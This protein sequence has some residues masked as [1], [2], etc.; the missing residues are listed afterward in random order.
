MLIGL[1]LLLLEFIIKYFIYCFSYISRCLLKQKPKTN[2]I[3]LQQVLKV[4]KIQA[5]Y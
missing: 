2:C 4:Y 1:L 3:P 5:V